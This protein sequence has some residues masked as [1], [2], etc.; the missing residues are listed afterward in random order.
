ML[1]ITDLPDFAPFGI[2]FT[3]FTVGIL[4]QPRE[5]RALPAKP[6]STELSGPPSDASCAKGELRGGRCKLWVS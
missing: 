3:T 4:S 1:F 2:S 6:R 5:A